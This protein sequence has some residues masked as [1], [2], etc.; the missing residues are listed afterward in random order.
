M[1]VLHLELVV[2]KHSVLHLKQDHLEITGG[3]S[4]ADRAQAR[5]QDA[6]MVCFH[7]SGCVLPRVV[8]VCP[9]PQGPHVYRAKHRILAH[10]DVH[11]VSRDSA[12]KMAAAA[13]EGTR[14]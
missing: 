11:S 3:C 12:T 14:N 10:F 4:L 13:L 7:S 5:F 6:A 9:S 1:R 2:G 8:K